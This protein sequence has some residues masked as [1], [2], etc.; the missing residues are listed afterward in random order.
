MIDL[1]RAIAR[2]IVILIKGAPGDC[3]S[4]TPSLLGNM[5]GDGAVREALRLLRVLHIHGI[6]DRGYGAYT[7]CL[8]DNPQLWAIVKRLPIDEAVA[9]LMWLIEDALDGKPIN[10]GPSY[11][12]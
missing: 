9:W 12:L 3:I 10:T 5:T 11:E 4:I 1:K 2:V 8:E 6:L 7:L